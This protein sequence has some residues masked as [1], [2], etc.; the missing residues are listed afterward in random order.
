MT[1]WAHRR[2]A[3]DARAVTA[4]GVAAGALAHLALAVGYAAAIAWAGW[5]DGPSAFTGRLAATLPQ[6]L[7]DYAIK[8]ALT[9]GVWLVV[10]R[11]E[12][13]LLLAA[14]AVL[15]PL[16]VAAWYLA[17]RSVAPALG[18]C[19]LEG[20]GQAWDV[21]IPAL[22]YVSTFGALHAARHLADVRARARAEAALAAR[23]ARLER[24]AQAAQLAALRAQM[25]PHFLFNTLNTV[26]ASV[27]AELGATRD[28]VG[29]LAALVRYTLGAARRET[30]PLRDELAFVR[31]Y[32]ALEGERMGARL[33]AEVSADERALDLPV[34]PMLLQPLV[35]NAVRHGLAPAVEGGTVWVEVRHEDGA[36][37]VRVADDGAGPDR[38]PAELL[39]AGVGLANTDA[40]LRALT[41]RG[42]TL[43]APGADPLRPGFEVAFRLPAAVTSGAPA[44]LVPAP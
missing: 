29:R 6:A 1:A 43:A 19:V 2:S 13:R 17:Y 10:V 35:E 22:V 38:R 7:V 16:W 42:L 31:D 28:L 23:N 34:P 4:W 32:L 3:P 36:L 20:G 27:P 18:F 11:L 14:H 12:G 21:F 5:A 8:G 40:R 15:G 30:V 33:R 25:D 37:H 24:T 44:P 39:S 41:G 9:L 26:A